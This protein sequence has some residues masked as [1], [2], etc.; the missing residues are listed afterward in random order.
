MSNLKKE[1]CYEPGTREGKET[2]TKKEWTV[3]SVD[4]FFSEPRKE[5]VI[6]E[7][8]HSSVDAKYPRNLELLHAGLQVF[9]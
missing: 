1:K 5:P 3:A 9:I 8:C 6:P 7:S 2:G 4:Q